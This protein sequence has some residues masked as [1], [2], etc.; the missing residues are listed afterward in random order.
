MVDISPRVFFMSLASIEPAFLML[1]EV[2]STSFPKIVRKVR[3]KALRRVLLA[4]PPELGQAGSSLG[5]VQD[6][7]KVVA[8][9]HRA[10]PSSPI[11][12]TKI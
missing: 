3:L 6:L 5:A 8:S 11:T 2:G 12:G 4:Q 10:L 7:L 1:P 9:T